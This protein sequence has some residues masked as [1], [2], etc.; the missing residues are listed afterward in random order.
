MKRCERGSGRPQCAGTTKGPSRTHL[1]LV[2]VHGSV[3]NH[4]A[5]LLQALGLANTNLFVQQETLLKNTWE[6]NWWQQQQQQQQQ[7]KRGKGDKH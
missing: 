5:S 6:N 1:N 3:S 2:S 4:D 7:T